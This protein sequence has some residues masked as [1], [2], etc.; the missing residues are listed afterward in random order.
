MRQTEFACRVGALSSTAQPCSLVSLYHLHL[1]RS[2]IFV[3][4][5]YRSPTLRSSRSELSNG[6][7]INRPQSCATT[8]ELIS[9]DARIIAHQLL[10]ERTLIRYGEIVG[11]SYDG[12]MSKVMSVSS[13]HPPWS[14]RFAPARLLCRISQALYIGTFEV[15]AE[16]ENVS[17][18]GRVIRRD[19]METSALIPLAKFTALVGPT[20]YAGTTA[21][22]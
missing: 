20:L 10:Y 16:T 21:Q 13:L 1:G 14:A 2:S 8:E 4:A 22:C 17:R 19:A 7:E 6:R 12:S 3:G 9:V 11:E 15:R 18:I 5:C